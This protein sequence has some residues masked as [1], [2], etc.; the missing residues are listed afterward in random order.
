MSKCKSC[1]AEIFWAMTKGNRKMPVDSLP[2]PGGNLTIVE[3]KNGEPVALNA[4]PGPYLFPCK[5][6]KSHFAT[7]P[8]A[9]EHRRER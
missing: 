6:Y 4:G 3:N 8:N 9:T 1:G 5:L 7:C 2:S